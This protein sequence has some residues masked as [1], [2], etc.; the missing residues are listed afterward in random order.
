MSET[1]M[2]FSLTAAT[3]SELPVW[4]FSDVLLRKLRPKGM[5]IL[6]FVITAV[7]AFGYAYMPVPWL[8]LVFQLLHGPSFSVMWSAGVAYAADISTENTRAT[9]QGMFGGVTMGLRSALGTL[10]GGILFDKAGAAATFRFGGIIAIVG[11][12]LFIANTRGSA[13]S[14]QV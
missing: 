2:G 7:Q 5:L 10:I 1:L 6:S 4:F 14:A 12:I 3:L 9:A 11:L 13:R 8:I